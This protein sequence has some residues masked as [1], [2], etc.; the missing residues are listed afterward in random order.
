MRVTGS[1]DPR[2]AAADTL[3][4]KLPQRRITRGAAEGF[5][6]YGNQIGLA[7]GQVREWYHPGYK[8]KRLEIGAVVGAVRADSVRRERPLPGDRVILVGGR[9]GRDGIGGATGS[10]KA[11][12]T[13]SLATAGA[14]VQKGNPVEERKLQ[15]LFRNER[16]ARL[17]KRCNDFGAGGVAVAVGELAPGLTINL[18]LVP[19]K[20]SGLSPLETALSESQERMAIVVEARDV[21]KAIAIAAEENL[22]ATEIARVTED[23]RLVMLHGARV[24]ASI[25]RA[26][27][28]SNGAP[29]TALAWVEAPD[30][31]LDPFTLWPARRA[32]LGFAG[33]MKEVLSDLNGSSQ[34]G[35]GERFDGSIG[36]ASLFLP[37]GGEARLTPAEGMAA[38]LP[39]PPSLETCTASFMA[40]GFDPELSA[41]S[42]FHGG[43]WSVV[44]AITKIAAM[45][46][47][48]YAGWLS[49]QEYFE[50]L[51]DDPKAWGK[52]VAALLGAWRAQR[53]TGIPAIGGKDSMSGSFG[54]LRVP[55]TLVAF[56]VATGNACRALS[57]ELKRAGSLLVLLPCPRDAEGLP[58]FRR[59][60]SNLDGLRVANEKGKVLSASALKRG[61]LLETVAVMA[62]GNGLGVTFDPG[63]SLDELAEPAFG[64]LVLELSDGSSPEVEL[65]G[66]GARIIG[67]TGPTNSM[68]AGGL[69]DR[70]DT[71]TPVFAWR[72][73]VLTLS[74]AL[75]AFVGTLEGV[76]PT[77]CASLSSRQAGMDAPFQVL[78][79][80]Q[81]SIRPSREGQSGASKPLV[82]LPVFPGTNCEFDT[83]RA[84]LAAGAR[85]ETLVFRNR[86]AW[87]LR[88]S[89]DEL[90]GLISRCQILAFPG[91]FSAGDEPDGSG[92]FIASVMRNNALAD[93]VHELVKTRK[94]LV[95]GICNGFQAL[96]KLGLLPYGEIRD[97]GPDSPTLAHNRIGRHVSDVVMTRVAS[98]ASPWLARCETGQLFKVPVSHGEGRFTAPPALLRQLAEEGR[99]VSQYVDAVGRPTETFPGNPN[100]SDLGIEAITSP[101]GLIL[102]KMGHPERVRKGTLVNI[103]D[104]RPQPIFEAG[105]AWFS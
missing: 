82:C 51:G 7:T 71:T 97:L 26:L 57:P 62:F 80:T 75:A 63:L 59:L 38:L 5:S 83:E 94:G 86:T 49:L 9:T 4:G 100:G 95:L 74:E 6:G 60:S 19:L 25:P 103:P 24:I 29:R 46:A 17:V 37:F 44:I 85:V 42:P 10:S 72:D 68:I 23:D 88:Q 54:E 14:E 36:A 47:D 55:P 73:Q 58:D 45:G 31:T 104:L 28:D 92:K 16:F 52:P 91:G 56:A 43:L 84:F 78:P 101:D 102:G 70:V 30:S 15:R 50:R 18:D 79:R 76:F 12:D 61:G 99:I 65:P 21:G 64:S 41:W 11:H 77:A 87:D 69:G 2:E 39:V 81:S 35:L 32:A 8:A 1:A 48:P 90:A 96:V 93:S 13:S 33:A 66:R 3:P 27:L 53:E 22:E 34:K 98:T 105:V 89:I 40:F 67:R 20:Y